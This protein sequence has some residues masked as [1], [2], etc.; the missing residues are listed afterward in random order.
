MRLCFIVIGIKGV[1][2]VSSEFTLGMN[3][4]R[5]M[6]RLLVVSKGVRQRDG[7]VDHQDRTE[8]DLQ[9]KDRVL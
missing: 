4:V 1:E 7:S 8:K 3:I 2:T 9:D 6:Q 5:R